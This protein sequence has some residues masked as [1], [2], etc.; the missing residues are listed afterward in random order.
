MSSMVTVGLFLQVAIKWPSAMKKWTEVDNAMTVYGFPR[1][2]NRNLQIVA[3]TVMIAAASKLSKFRKTE[4]RQEI[5]SVEHS[6]FLAF[7]ILNGPHSQSTLEAFMLYQQGMFD[8]VFSY[9]P[10]SLWI[11]MPL[12]VVNKKVFSSRSC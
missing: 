10:Y 11:G 12:Q 1:K 9:V 3:C 8:H 7:A 5:I 6:F 2:L 4:A